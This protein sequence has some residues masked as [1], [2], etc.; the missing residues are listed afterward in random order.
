MERRP[1]N[2]SLFLIAISAACLFAACGGGVKFSPPPGM[3]QLE[4]LGHSQKIL[5]AHYPGKS[6]LFFSAP[7][8]KGPAPVY[9]VVY[10]STK[11]WTAFV[12]GASQSRSWSEDMALEGASMTVT[13]VTPRQ[14]FMGDLQKDGRPELLFL[15]EVES[16]HNKTGATQK[17]QAIYLYTLARQLTLSWYKT[18]LIKGAGQQDC[19]RQSLAYSSTP[20]FVVDEEGAVTGIDV[21]HALTSVDCTGGSSCKVA[22]S[23]QRERDTGTVQLQWDKDLNVF[24]PKG[25]SEA[26]LRIPDVSL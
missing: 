21:D 12:A 25:E 6:G 22:E 2:S 26:V 16:K 15:V 7:G 18:L 1:K 20:K 13:S 9:G 17:R 10:D 11:P 23:C 4:S 3:Q 5:D 19:G 24:L 8:A 14:A